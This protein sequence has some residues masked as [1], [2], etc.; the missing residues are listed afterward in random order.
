MY[1]VKNSSSTCHGTNDVKQATAKTSQGWSDKSGGIS[2]NQVSVNC[3]CV[4]HVQ[5][6]ALPRIEGEVPFALLFT[7][8]ELEGR[9][10]SQVALVSYCMCRWRIG[11]YYGGLPCHYA[12]LLF[13]QQNRSR[14]LLGASVLGPCGY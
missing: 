3:S 13:V 14:F 12:C 7:V 8:S 4:G 5:M 6:F 1:D 10:V 9:S 11:G 2:M